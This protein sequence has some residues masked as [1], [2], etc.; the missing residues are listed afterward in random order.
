MNSEDVAKINKIKSDRQLGHK[1]FHEKSSIYRI[2]TE[3]EKKTFTDGNL[4]KMHKE[5]IAIGISLVNGCEPCLEWHIKQAKDAGATD[6][7]IIEALEVGFEMGI[8]P[9]TVTARFAMKV[10]QYYKK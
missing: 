6:E 2:F 7:Q 9:T 10:L 3:M 4:S 5:L 1:F 8:G